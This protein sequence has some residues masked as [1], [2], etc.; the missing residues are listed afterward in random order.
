MFLTTIITHLDIIG[1]MLYLLKKS[2]TMNKIKI[3]S[4]SL[5]SFFLLFWFEQV[6]A[7]G[8]TGKSTQ[9]EIADLN[10]ELSV[11]HSS[12]KVGTTVVFTIVVENEGSAQATGVTVMDKLPSGY[13]YLKSSPFKGVYNIGTG[14]WTIGSL[15]ANTSATLT[16]T[17]KV[18][19]VGEYMNIAEI[20]ACD[21]ADPDS[22]PASGVDTNKNNRVVDDPG[23]EDDGDGQD[24]T[25]VNISNQGNTNSGESGSGGEDSAD[26]S[27][28]GDG[29]NAESNN[30][31]GSDG[32]NSGDENQEES[33]DAAN[34]MPP[35]IVAFLSASS[36]YLQKVIITA[37]DVKTI[38]DKKKESMTMFF[39]PQIKAMR[40]SFGETEIQVIDKEKSGFGIGSGQ[41]GIVINTKPGQ[42]TKEMPMYFDNNG[43][44]YTAGK[45]NEYMKV[46]FEK[47]AKLMP[48]QGSLFGVDLPFNLPIF[49]L[50]DGSVTYY[51][52]DVSPKK[53]PI[54]EWAFVYRTEAFEG[55]SGFSKE[56]MD[57]TGSTNCIKYTM[58]AGAD[59]GS[60]VLFDS[61]KRLREIHSK[62]SGYIVYTYQEVK[63][64]LPDATDM[65]KYF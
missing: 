61:K 45:K 60:Y 10:L 32:D 16:I 40:V 30:N 19:P 12:V 20:T 36:M 39:D 34:I 35:G 46:P 6:Q 38:L 33:D 54:L 13:T 56:I 43:Y 63:V 57:C 24:V 50:P 1:K 5:I 31:G 15:A 2:S 52:M 8:D 22:K 49:S 26:N 42:K 44:V 7:L 48:G 55:K 9:K 23:D 62:N 51:G 64:N 59:A 11:N 53:F 65:S 28:G 14:L 29:S 4:M 21:Q 25:I 27:G 17:A 41:G 58:T 3:I 47:M 18:N 37:G